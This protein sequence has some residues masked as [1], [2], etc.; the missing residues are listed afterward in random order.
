[1]LTAAPGASTAPDPELFCK[2]L[3]PGLRNTV[4]PGAVLS[5]KEMPDWMEQGD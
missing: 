2:Y 3:L 4:K 5:L 1:M